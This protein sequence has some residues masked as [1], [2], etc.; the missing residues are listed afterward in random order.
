LRVVALHP[1]AARG[2]DRIAHPFMPAKVGAFFH[3]SRLELRAFKELE[4]RRLIMRTP[5]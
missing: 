1:A 4:W 5:L 3:D 2:P